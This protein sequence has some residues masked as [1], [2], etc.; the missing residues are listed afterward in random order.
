METKNKII[1]A[2]PMAETVE[3][4][5]E[6]VICE[7]GLRNSYGNANDGVDSSLLDGNGIWNW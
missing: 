5:A 6:G 1:Y 2:P 7:S 3:V 4:Q